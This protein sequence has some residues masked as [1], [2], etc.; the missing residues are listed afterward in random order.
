MK[1]LLKRARWSGGWQAALETDYFLLGFLLHGLE[2]P[3]SPR[4]TAL[5]DE[6]KEP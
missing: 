6:Y 1:L 5:N 4:P 3:S 2:A